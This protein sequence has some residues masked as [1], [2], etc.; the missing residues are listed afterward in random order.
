M[1]ACSHSYLMPRPYIV[2][3][4]DRVLQLCYKCRKRFSRLKGY[5]Y[6]GVRR[7]DLEN[8]EPSIRFINVLN[9]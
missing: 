1:K 2:V 5:S 8:L 7:R 4:D 9:R 3:L 6:L